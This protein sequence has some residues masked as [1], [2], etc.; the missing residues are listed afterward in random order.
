MVADGTQRPVRQPNLAALDLDAAL[1]DFL[2][3]I[4]GADGAEQLAFGSRCR[5]DL[6]RH[7][8]ELLG[9]RLR[10]RELRGGFRLELGTARLE[11]RL[12]LGRRQRRLA[13]RDQVIPRVARL[14]ANEIA[15]AADIV[16][17]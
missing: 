2:G 14:Y 16:D 9:T 4:D 15:D 5:L 3:N 1:A 17:F 12:V 6:P 8:L 13:L 10:G 7:P 11:L